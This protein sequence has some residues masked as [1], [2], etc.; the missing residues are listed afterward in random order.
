MGIIPHSKTNEIKVYVDKSGKTLPLKT[1]ELGPSM[2][3]RLF[4]ISGYVFTTLVL[5][6][7][8]I[9]YTQKISRYDLLFSLW[10]STTP[11]SVCLL[12]V[13]FQ[14]QK[15][16]LDSLYRNL[17]KLVKSIGKHHNSFVTTE[18]ILTALLLLVAFCLRCVIVGI[19]VHEGHFYPWFEDL[20]L[21]ILSQ[22]ASIVTA[23]E[24][25][26]T[27][28]ISNC[29][30]IRCQQIL[31]YW[32]TEF[33]SRGRLHHSNY[34]ENMM[35]MNVGDDNHN[36]QAV[37]GNFS[38][39]DLNNDDQVLLQIEET[40]LETDRV[41]GDLLKVY[42]YPNLYL[43]INF[44]AN[45]IFTF[46]FGASNVL[47]KI[48][49]VERGSLTYIYIVINSLVM[50]FVLHDPADKFQESVSIEEKESYNNVS[51]ANAIF[52]YIY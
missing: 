22:I 46:Y 21:A 2:M 29:L 1:I 26:H 15:S 13:C 47:N 8:G 20:S 25:Y 24:Y 14:R 52:S 35:N 44:L 9:V 42:G 3:F 11:T 23:C 38:K 48:F 17:E 19:F 40:F 16:T 12:L 39:K 27:K 5:V 37:D 33:R 49:T 7:N 4:V 45:I 28:I 34:E 18:E 50:I 6:I 51:I 32:T 31:E 10:I 30:N 36:P 43:S 41:L